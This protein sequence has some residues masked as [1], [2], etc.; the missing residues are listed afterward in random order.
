LEWEAGWGIEITCGGGGGWG[1][2]ALGAGVQ[3][4]GKKYL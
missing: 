4:Y 3:C 1:G 2:G